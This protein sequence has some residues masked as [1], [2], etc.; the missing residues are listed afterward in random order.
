MKSKKE[1]KNSKKVFTIMLTSNRRGE[2][3]SFTVS[4]AWAKATIVLAL[5]FIFV[6]SAILLDYSSLLYDERTSRYLKEE[7]I[8]LKEKFKQVESK[9]GSLERSLDR[10]KAYSA[11]LKLITNIDD[12]DR[13][14]KLSM[15]SNV[16][17]NQN[18]RNQH[19]D[20]SQRPQ[21]YEYLVEDD[22][23]LT[24]PIIDGTDEEK[25]IVFFEESQFSSL[26]LRIKRSV[27]EAE[28]REQDS[29]DLYSELVEKQQLI[30][31]TPSI[32]P[33]RGWF[34]S[35]FGYRIDPFTGRPKM[36]AGLDMAAA[37]GTPVVAPADG[38]VSFAGYEPG[39]GKLIAIDH[40]YGVKTRYAHNS[41]LYVKLGQK[42]KRRDVIAAVGNTGRSSG[43]HL[44]Y[45]VRVN[46]LPV[47]PI[48]YILDE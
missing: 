13:A 3:K 16:R 41:K 19:V 32:K 1:N 38:I 20:F 27:Q 28:L 42:V 46:G 9:V 12:D 29:M 14:L 40:G 45:E 25:Q 24:R 18:I 39:Y 6:I 33:T 30:E 2:V 48:N 17:E 23:L 36:H 4:S 44:H 26:I 15:G 21:E 35:S 22:G 8:F 34:S 31:S 47:D 11:K 10:V 43:P 7:N 5:F 37:P